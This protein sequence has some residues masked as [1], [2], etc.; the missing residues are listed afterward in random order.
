MK[1]YGKASLREFTRKVRPGR[2]PN[3]IEE[4]QEP[5]QQAEA[6]IQQAEEPVQQAEEVVEQRDRLNF[7][8]R[9]VGAGRNNIRNF[10][11]TALR[12]PFPEAFQ[13]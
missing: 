5:V 9:D 11:Y 13:G 10:I 1:K 6:L 8:N 12:L 7:A 2:D 4:A 3:E